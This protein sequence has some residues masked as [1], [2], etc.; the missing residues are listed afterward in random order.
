MIV[1]STWFITAGVCTKFCLMVMQDLFLPKTYFFQNQF[2]YPGPILE[3]GYACNF[4]K[5]E[6]NI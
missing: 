5:K 3:S 4:L 2:V 1:T 6:Q